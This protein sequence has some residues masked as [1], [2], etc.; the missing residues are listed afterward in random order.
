MKGR[1]LPVPLRIYRGA[2]TAAAVLAPARLNYRV[3][4]GKEDPSRIGERRGFTQVARPAGP[5]IWVHGASVGEIVSVLPLVERLMG[6]GFS[7]LLT[8][9][10]LTSSRIAARG[11]RAE[12]SISS[13]RWTPRLRPPLPRPLAA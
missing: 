6:R 7:F 5:L 9:G 11:R 4:K 1:G 10:T 3:S 12:S 13:C 8:S 2:A